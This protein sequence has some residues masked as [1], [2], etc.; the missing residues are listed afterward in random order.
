MQFSERTG[1]IVWTREL[2]STKA[3]EK[4]GNVH[5]VSRKM[6]YVVLYV[7]AAEAEE[8]IAQLQKLPFVKSVER[9]LRGEI[10]TE[11]T[12]TLADKTRTYSV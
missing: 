8:I 10:P 6:K 4:V 7:N 3:F 2:R 5:Y 11:Y 9:S 12:G 1:L